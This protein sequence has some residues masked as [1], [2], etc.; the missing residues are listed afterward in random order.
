MN[1]SVTR[2][3]SPLTGPRPK[4]LAAP[5][6]TRLQQVPRWAWVSLVVGLILVGSSMA[7]VQKQRRQN[8][9]VAL[10]AYD[11]TPAQVRECSTTL[12][13]W[14]VSHQVNLEGNKLFVHPEIRIELLARL[15]AK[16]I[17]ARDFTSPQSV[18]TLTPSRRQQ[19]AQEKAQLEE[20][21]NQSLRSL[22]G[23]ESADVNLAIPEQ[24]FGE[25]NRPTASVVLKL[26][27]G[28][29]LPRT[30]AFGIARLISGAVPCLRAEDVSVIDPLGVQVNSSEG[31]SESWQLELQKQLDDYLA[32]KAQKI[33]DR[34]YGPGRAECAINVELDYSQMEV[35][36]TDAGPGVVSGEQKLMEVYQNE[37]KSDLSEDFESD[38]KGKRYEKICEVRKHKNNEAYSWVVHKLPRI[39]KLTCA[40]LIDTKGQADNALAL[41]RGAIGF[42]P[43][44]GDEVNVAIVPMP[45]MTLPTLPGP[46]EVATP[47]QQPYWPLVMGMLGAV[48]ACLALAVGL[49]GVRR[50]RQVDMQTQCAPLANP[51][52]LCDLS[53]PASGALPAQATATRS[54][55]YQLEEKAR[56]HPEKIASLLSTTY[57][58]GN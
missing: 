6:R 41:V 37:Q 20:S 15:A 9:P 13:Q 33:L 2:R 26:A 47:G 5:W 54:L 27:H 40:V 3:S 25:E 31:A 12:A 8:D 21:L 58:R 39:N 11:L 43:G 19:L 49:L 17:P 22:R 48:G 34:A 44:R 51:Q 10:F 38:K 53:H 24:S 56:E 18:A 36:R 30:Q 16:D 29:N 42:D 35:K 14:Q 45:I 32:G 7:L 23:I 55:I 28:Y 1:S 57:L 50:V 4:A 52:A 46:V